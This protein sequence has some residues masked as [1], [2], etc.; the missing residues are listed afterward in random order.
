M[1]GQLSLWNEAKRQMNGEELIEILDLLHA[2]SYLWD[3][4][5]VFYAADVPEIW[6]FMKDRVLRMLKGQ[7]KSVVRGA[8][9]MATK[10]KISG[11]KLKKLGVACNYFDKNQHRMKYD[12]YLEMGALPTNQHEIKKHL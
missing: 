12:E 7:I 8:R 3:I 4:A 10:R 2:I 9:Q 1:D 5:H 11:K 6:G